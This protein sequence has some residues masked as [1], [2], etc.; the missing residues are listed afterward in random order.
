MA[1]YIILLRALN[2]GNRKA[3]MKELRAKCEAL[4]MTDVGSYIASG[5]LVAT[6]TM[7]SAEIEAAI[8]TL[9]ERDYGFHSDTIVR[10]LAQW[11]RIVADAPFEDER[12]D[13]PARLHLCLTK[14]PPAAD[15]VERLEARATLGE[16]FILVGD[17]LWVD[18]AEGVGNSKLTPAIFDKSAGSPLTARNWNTVQK[19]LDLASG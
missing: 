5:N 6:S 7:P 1:R 15:I 9:V 4:G 18:F 19:L 12:R 17:A 10:T 2:T 14:R 16:R 11:E 13:R 8:E 3:P